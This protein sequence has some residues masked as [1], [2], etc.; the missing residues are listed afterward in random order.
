MRAL[1][2]GGS[3]RSGLSAGPARRGELVLR[4]AAHGGACGASVRGTG[5]RG[6]GW[7]VLRPEVG[8]GPAARVPA[9]GQSAWHRL[10]GR[11]GPQGC[12]RRVGPE[13][14]TAAL[15]ARRPAQAS[16]RRCGPPAGDA[17][18]CPRWRDWLRGQ[19]LDPA[20][21]D[22]WPRGDPRLPTR[23]RGSAELGMS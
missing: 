23:G 15:A 19:S 22:P 1:G 2:A 7:R 17:C 10:A 20:A 4:G 12:G 14:S 18:L 11:G 21:A 8:A 13:R 16:G 3:T 5:G 6:P 9:V